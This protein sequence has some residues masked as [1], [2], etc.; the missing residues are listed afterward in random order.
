MSERSPRSAVPALAASAGL[1]L[2]ALLAVFQPGCLELRD[3]DEA[4]TGEAR[5]ASCHGDPDRP[6]DFLAR[7]SPPIDLLGARD[8]AYPGVGAHA[9]HLNDSQTHIAIAC[10]ECHVVP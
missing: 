3:S 4:A 10:S 6:G 1:L 5:C 9:I 8:I 2:S 7:S